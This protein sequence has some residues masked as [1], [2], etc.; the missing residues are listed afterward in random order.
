[1]ALNSAGTLMNLVWDQQKSL[2]GFNPLS[3]G[4]DAVSLS[5]NPALTGSNPANIVF[6]EQRTLAAAGSY[7]YDMTTGLTD[8]LGTAINLTRIF[9]VIITSS[10]GTVVYQPGASNGLEWFLGGTSPTISI[11]AG[12]GFLFSTPTHQTVSGTD[13][14]IT[15]SS[16]AGAT[17]KIAFLGGQ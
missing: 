7:T 5:V 11:P 16:V 6:A 1:M 15:L 13:K 12:A 8:F 10:S 4:S 2:T 17:Y 3:Q 9:A 14:T